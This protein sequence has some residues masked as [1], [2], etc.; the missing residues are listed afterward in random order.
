VAEECAA[1]RERQ[2]RGR[3][4][5]AS[6]KDGVFTG[7]LTDG[8]TPLLELT[9][10]AGSAKQAEALKRKFERDAET[11]LQQIWGIMVNDETAGT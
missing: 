8:C 7:T 3:C 1:A 5:A 9:L 11:I 10:Q 2:L 6:E 4:V